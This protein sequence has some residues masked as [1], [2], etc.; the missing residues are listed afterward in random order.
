MTKITFRRNESPRLWDVFADGKK[1]GEFYYE[2]TRQI[3]RNRQGSR[4]VNIATYG[5]IW[6]M[7]RQAQDI[8]FCSTFNEARRYAV[9][10]F[11]GRA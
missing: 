9:E 6:D 1:V 5:R 11:Q 7:D 10:K 2:R 3:T 8:S 4:I